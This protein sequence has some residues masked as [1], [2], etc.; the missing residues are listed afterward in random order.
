MEE[1][2][3]NYQLVNKKRKRPTSLIVVDIFFAI[4]I[5]TIICYLIFCLI[6]VQAQV[7]GTSMQPTFNINLSYEDDA[8]SS[9]YKDIVYANRFDKGQNGD[10]VIAKVNNDIVIK[11]LV[12]TEGQI[13]TL[14][15]ESDG[16]YHFYLS[17]EAGAMPKKLDESYI[18]EF[19]QYMN[20]GY[21]LR[22]L[23]IEGVEED[24]MLSGSSAS[25][26]IPEDCVFLLGDNRQTSE[27]STTY[28]PISES[29]IM[30]TVQFYHYY[31]QSLIS[32]LWQQFCSIF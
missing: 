4:Y 25:L 16:Y 28:G 29:K 6:F 26:T 20:Y 13:L 17:N 19:R 15:Y 2:Y 14:K 12:A 27:D 23:D 32:Y 30:G 18:G 8:T 21:F 3:F 22:F 24:G 5:L 9:P 1:K 7:I 10:I 11:R 31:N